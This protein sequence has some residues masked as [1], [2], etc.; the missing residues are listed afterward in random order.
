[1]TKRQRQLAHR[2]QQKARDRRRLLRQVAYEPLEQRQM[3]SGAELPP[4][5]ILFPGSNPVPD[6]FGRGGGSGAFQS[7]SRWTTTATNPGPLSQGD[8]TTLTWS[9][10]PDGVNIP[11]GSGEN[12]AASN[13]ISFL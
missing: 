7:T 6:A 3:L 9:V 12:A 1:M 11:G 10:F 8:A 4:D 2:K 5:P 13:L